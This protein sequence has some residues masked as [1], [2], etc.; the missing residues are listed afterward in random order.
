MLHEALGGG[1]DD[2]RE[3]KDDPAANVFGPKVLGLLAIATSIDALAAGVTLA[4]GEVHIGFACAVI[5]V[6]TAVLSFLGVMAGHRF[7]ARL[8][9]RLEVLGGLVLVG[10]ALKTLIEHF[11]G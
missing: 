11:R 10:L 5:G 8:G 4:L 6:V 2:E 9:K 1:V 3:K 7:G